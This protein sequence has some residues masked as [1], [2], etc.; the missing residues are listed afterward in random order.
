[1]MASFL[2]GDIFWCVREELGG[3]TWPFIDLLK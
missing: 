3:H 2:V 1:M